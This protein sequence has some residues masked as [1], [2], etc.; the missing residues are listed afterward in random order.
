MRSL[1]DKNNLDCFPICE[2]TQRCHEKAS[3][4]FFSHSVIR[5]IPNT[6]HDKANYHPPTRW[7]QKSA[8]CKQRTALLIM[9][10]R[11]NGEDA[12]L[13]KQTRQSA[14][15]WHE[16]TSGALGNG[17][18]RGEWKPSASVIAGGRNPVWD[19]VGEEERETGIWSRVWWKMS[20]AEPPP[21]AG[22]E[23][24]CREY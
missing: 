1:H 20:R 2:C 4:S 22:R 5:D 17:Q 12:H 14:H 21:L 24:I 9:S 13:H 15:G 19:P 7:N 23:K 6:T 8:S 11:A 18:H 16:W 3:W 10:H